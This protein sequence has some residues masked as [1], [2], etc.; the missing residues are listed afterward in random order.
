MNLRSLELIGNACTHIRNNKGPNIELCGN[1]RTIDAIL[2]Q[3]PARRH[4]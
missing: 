3:M 2:E 4:F 1:P